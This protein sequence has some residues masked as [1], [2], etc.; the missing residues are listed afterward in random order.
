MRGGRGTR[1]RRRPSAWQRFIEA[2]HSNQNFEYLYWFQVNMLKLHDEIRRDVPCDFLAMLSHP[3]TN[4]MPIATRGANFSP[5]PH[6]WRLL[7][8]FQ[9]DGL[10]WIILHFV[11]ISPVKTRCDTDYELLYA[12][13]EVDF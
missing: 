10:D 9:E 11:N 4:Q 2:L 12:I 7:F 1:E 5:N 8:F 13:L 3:D 6:V